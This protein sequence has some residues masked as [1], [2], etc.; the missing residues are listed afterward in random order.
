MVV[1]TGWRGDTKAKME[2]RWK[3]RWEVEAARF[4]RRAPAWTEGWSSR[5]MRVY[6]DVPKHVAT[7]IFLLRSEVLGLRA[8]LSSIGVPGVTP[9]CQCGHPRQTIQHVLAF[10]PD[11]GEARTQLLHRAGHTQLARLL[12]EKD[13][14]SMAGRWLL[15]TGLLKYFQVAID[16]EATDT[17]D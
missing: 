1:D 2:E 10:C 4:P 8:W 17:G 3:A 5:P 13:T 9:E 6:D 11:L 15:D 12:R 16:V 14:A 7:A